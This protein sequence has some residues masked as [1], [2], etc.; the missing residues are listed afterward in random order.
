MGGLGVLLSIVF[1]FI[2]GG[3]EKVYMTSVMAQDV[4]CTAELWD[5]I[6]RSLWSVVYIVYYVINLLSADRS[7]SH[8]V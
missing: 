2:V 4:D 6:D 5:V 3:A 8:F 1:I 7:C